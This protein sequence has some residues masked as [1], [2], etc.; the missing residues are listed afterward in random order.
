MLEYAC[1]DVVFHFNKAHLTDPTIPMW[2]LKHHGDTM[3]VNHVD[4]R[5]GWSTKETPDNSHT[6]GSI[7]IKHCLLI[8]DDDNCATITELTEHDKVRLKHKA[9]G[10][11]RIIIPGHVFSK[12]ENVLKNNKIKHTPIKRVYGAC[13]STFYI[14]DVLD[15]RHMTML[16]LSLSNGDYRILKDNEDYFKMYDDPKYTTDIDEDEYYWGN[17]DDDDDIDDNTDTDDE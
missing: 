14:T 7:K 4:C 1:T 5:V 16:S 8:I 17:D 2:V 13:S 6:K 15:K 9:N 12:V 3:Y 10:I 11:T